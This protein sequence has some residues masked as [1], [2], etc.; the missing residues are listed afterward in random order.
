MF[1]IALATMLFSSLA[2][3][4]PPG[5]YESPRHRIKESDGLATNERWG[6]HVRLTGLSGIGALP[7]VNF[8]GEVA[9]HLRRDAMFGELSLGRLTPEEDYRVVENRNKP[10][11]LKLDLWTLRAGWSSMRMPMRAWL[12]FEVG[13]IAGARGMQGVVS[14]MVMGDTPSA[15]Q[16]RAAG[17]G[18]GVAWPMSDQARLFGSMEIAVP[19]SREPLMLDRGGAYEPDPFSMRCSLGL[20]VGWR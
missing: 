9:V 14:R 7:G 5:S 19:L 13:E 6:G 16:W 20:E 17:G 15:Q 4:Q 2:F 12:L 8:G 11:D 10:V 1:K 18:F 3:A